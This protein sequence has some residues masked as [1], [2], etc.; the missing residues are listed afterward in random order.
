MLEQVHEFKSEIEL[1]LSMNSE[2][3]RS[4]VIAIQ[5]ATLRFA[6]TQPNTRD[7]SEHQPIRSESSCHS[8]IWQHISVGKCEM[9]L[10]A[11]NVTCLQILDA[12]GAQR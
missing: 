7:A 1:L 3:F 6:L 10:R 9:E 12:E 8:N 2:L 5:F 11:N 4:T